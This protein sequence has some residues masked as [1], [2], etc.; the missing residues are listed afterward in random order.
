[1]TYRRPKMA[2]HPKTTSLAPFSRRSAGI[3]AVSSFVVL[4][5]FAGR[6]G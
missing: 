6:Y 3:A 4:M 5:L 2:V 1:M